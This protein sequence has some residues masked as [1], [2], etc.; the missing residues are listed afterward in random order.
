MANVHLQGFFKEGNNSPVKNAD[1]PSYYIKFNWIKT[2]QIKQLYIN[3]GMFN[4]WENYFYSSL[5]NRDKKIRF[6]VCF[7]KGRVFK[8]LICLN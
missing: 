6:I 8:I 2:K 3:V 1:I 5:D 7:I 4:I